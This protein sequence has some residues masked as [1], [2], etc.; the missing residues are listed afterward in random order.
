MIPPRIP[1]TKPSI[2]EHE[3][4]LATDAVRHGWGEQCYQYI[5]RFESDFK[6]YLGTKYALATSSCTGALHMGLAALE[7]GPDDEVV[8]ANIN[9]VATVSPVVHLGAKPVF[10]DVLPDTWCIDPARI[11]EAITPRTRAIIATHL[12]GNP[13]NLPEI[14]SIADEHNIPVI[15]DAAEAIGTQVDG[16]F[17]GSR[18]WFGVFSFHGTKTMTTGE[19]GMLVTNDADLHERCVTL[20]RH[21]QS[22]SAERQFW[23]DVAGYKFRISNVQAAIG[24][25]QLARIEELIARKRAIFQSYAHRLKNLPLT[26]NAEPSGTVNGY[27][28]PTVVFNEEVTFDRDRA[29]ARFSEN[30]I[31]ARVFFWPLSEMPPFR[32][33]VD[34]PV[35]H[36]IHS[37][38]INL[39]S[40]HDITNDQIQ[41]VCKVLEGCTSS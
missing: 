30:G 32:C 11:E 15:E 12:Y 17:A 2:T 5:N 39:P 14:F 41:T 25:A 24:C 35:A 33:E 23:A 26:M 6:R 34:T 18:G 38:A 29:L 31:D 7:V 36:S 8:L 1:Y 10:V 13:C 40:Y 22:L 20:S 27:W 28:M 4:A 3:V 9:W 16:S 37:R 21:G 19:G